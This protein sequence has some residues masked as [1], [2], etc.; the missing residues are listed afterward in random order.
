MLATNLIGILY[1][2]CKAEFS[3][4]AFYIFISVDLVLSGIILVVSFA[5]FGETNVCANNKIFYKFAVIDSI[6]IVIMALMI[7]FMPFYWIQKY[8]NSPGNL[9]WSFLFFGLNWNSNYE[10]KMSAIGVLC[11]IIS[12]LTLI[13]NGIAYWRGI[14]V[15]IKK[16]VIGCWAIALL[17]MCVS[18]I[19][20]IVAAF[21]SSDPSTYNDVAANKLLQTFLA[22]NIIEFIL[23]IFGLMTLNYENGDPIRDSLL[24]FGKNDSMFDEERE[25]KEENKGFGTIK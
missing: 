24:N 23:W 14:T 1:Q 3:K 7:L 4:I 9:V 25:S 8:S 12:A 16:I 18:E 5:G 13:S 17:L 10:S 11:L 19:I 20:A 2:R 22:L 6:F 15:T 21:Q